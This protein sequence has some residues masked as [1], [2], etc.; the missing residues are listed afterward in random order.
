MNAISA[1]LLNIMVSDGT[2]YLWGAVDSPSENE[3]VRAA[4]ESA[5]GI[6]RVSGHLFVPAERVRG[7]SPAEES[8]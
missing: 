8:L 4:A 3:A 1:H 7:G 6:T 2:P 5:P